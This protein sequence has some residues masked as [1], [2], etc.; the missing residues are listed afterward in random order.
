[1]NDLIILIKLRP[2]DLHSRLLTATVSSA[3]LTFC[4][5]HT[6]NTTFNHN[7]LQCLETDLEYREVIMMK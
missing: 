7:L 2:F 6:I 1:M 3:L 5:K 4:C